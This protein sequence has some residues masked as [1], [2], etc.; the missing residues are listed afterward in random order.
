MNG[1]SGPGFV[2]LASYGL[3]LLPRAIGEDEFTV[4]AAGVGNSGPVGVGPVR[5]L[6]GHTH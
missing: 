6:H 5:G 2:P 4:P 3:L 1:F